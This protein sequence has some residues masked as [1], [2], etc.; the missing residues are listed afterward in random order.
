VGEQRARE[1]NVVGERAVVGAST[2]R[3]VGR[4]LGNRMTGGVRG[5]ERERAGARVRGTALIDQPHRAARERDRERARG[6][7][8]TGGT[9]M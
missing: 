3:D 5:T 4:R 9:R 7:G 6:L 8:L 1:G 2:A